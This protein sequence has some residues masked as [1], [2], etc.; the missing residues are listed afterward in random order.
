MSIDVSTLERRATELM[1]QADFGPEAVRVNSEIIE[2]SPAHEAAWT[3]LGRCYLEQRQFDDAV[4]AL[5]SALSLNPSSGIATNLLTEV[6][7]RRALTPTAAER[8]TTGFSAREFAALE[9]LSVDDLKR[10]LG[11]RIDALFDAINATTIAEKIVD[12]RR[13][14]GESGTKLFHSNSFHANGTGQIAAFQHGGRW[15]PQFNIGW[16]SSPPLPS[17]CMRIGVGFNLS[18][19]GRD[20]ERVAGQERVLAFFECFQQALEKSWKRE[21]TRW[22]AATGGFIQYADHPPAVDLLP[23]QAVEWLLNCRHAAAHGWIF[24]GR[25]LFLDD[26]D[27]AKILGD[28]AQLAK[29][30]D[31]TF[32][33]LYPLWLATYAG[34]TGDVTPAAAP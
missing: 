17:R 29:A 5:R 6:R 8:I 27:D 3:R 26:P 33:T 28:R 19:A 10:A 18:Q 1:K 7:R 12:A 13:R 24:V 15:E 2:Q 14:Q 32:R 31:D 22:M 9:T 11:S 4:V 20:Q 34:T 25:W 16:F 23:E 30:V 21:L